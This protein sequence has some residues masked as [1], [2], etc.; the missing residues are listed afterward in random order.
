[1]KKLLPAKRVLLNVISLSLLSSLVLG[2]LL[3]VL[4]NPI[5]MTNAQTPPTSFWNVERDG[6]NNLNFSF[7]NNSAAGVV[8]LRLLP[9]GVINSTGALNVGS[10]NNTPSQKLMIN[11]TTTNDGLNLQGGNSTWASLLANLGGGSYNGI[12]S[13][14]DRGIIFGGASAG[15]PGGGFVITPWSNTL[16]G[17]KIAGNG[18][19]GIG[20]TAPSTKLDVDGNITQSVTHGNNMK[21]W[22][23]A[24]R[25]AGGTGEVGLYSWISEPGATWTGGAIARNMVNTTASFPRINTALSGQMMRFTEAGNIEFV[26]ETSGGVRTTPLTVTN[27]TV[28]ASRLEAPGAV[29]D[30]GLSTCNGGCASYHGQAL[31]AW[32]NVSAVGYGWATAQNT[33]TDVFSHNGAG[34]ITVLKSGLY[35]VKLRSMAMP[36]NDIHNVVVVITCINGAASSWGNTGNTWYKHQYHKAGWWAQE[37][38]EMTVNLDANTTIQYCYLFNDPAGLSYWAHDGYTSMQVTRIN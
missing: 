13:A 4:K 30:I 34:T 15:N 6:S 38:T 36:V 35:E 5:D 21:L 7:T 12:A 37:T 25:N 20:T 9:T 10:I 24:A 31:N 16:G 8:G 18:N 1:M 28:K 33:A 32:F 29:I 26:V 19:V 17:L 2:A 27:G 14:G 22:L 23:P 3:F 11:T